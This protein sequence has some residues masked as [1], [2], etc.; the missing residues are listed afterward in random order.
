MIDDYLVPCTLTLSTAKVLTVRYIYPCSPQGVVSTMILW[1]RELH[2]IEVLRNYFEHIYYEYDC[3]NQVI[4]RYIHTYIRKIDSHCFKLPIVSKHS[5]EYTSYENWT[6][7]LEAIVRY[8]AP[9][10]ALRTIGNTVKQP[11]G[12]LPMELSSSLSMIKGRLYS[13]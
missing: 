4:Y 13:F 2:G 6:T 9:K 7:I 12:D 3:L 8:T 11:S 5:V 1:I 10:N